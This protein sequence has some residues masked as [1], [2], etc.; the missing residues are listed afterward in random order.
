MKPPEHCG[1][2]SEIRDE[3]DQLDHQIIQLL[4]Q[5][6]GYVKAALRV[7][8]QEDNDKF[9]ERFQTMLN[10]RRH[11]AECEGLNPDIIESVYRDLIHRFIKEELKSWQKNQGAEREAG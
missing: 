7:R 6:M 3:I 11:W 5:R 10:D 2:I 8:N 1:D 9:S 4:G